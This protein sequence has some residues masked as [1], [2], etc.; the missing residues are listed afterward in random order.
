M[1]T[2]LNLLQT[3]LP[4]QG[5]PCASAVTFSSPERLPPDA[6]QRCLSRRNGKSQFAPLAL[7][8]I[9]RHSLLQWH[10]IHPSLSPPLA[11]RT[12]FLR[13][14]LRIRLLWISREQLSDYGCRF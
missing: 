9:R 14:H 12:S 1:P 3:L 5:C 13:P 10:S 7:R 8:C 6:R 11:R 2:E 4:P